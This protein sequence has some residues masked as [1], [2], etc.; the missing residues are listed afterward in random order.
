MKPLPAF[1][2]AAMLGAGS[3][4]SLEAQSA[5]GS[6]DGLVV[7]QSRA[8]VPGV[9]ITVLRPAT[10]ATRTLVT[11]A[12]GRFRAPL[13]PVGQYELTATLSGFQTI[14][15]DVTLTVGQSLSVHLELSA[16]GPAETVVVSA[17]AE[18]LERTR[19]SASSTVDETAIQNLP[20]NGRSFVDFALLTPGVTRDRTGDLSFAGQRSTLNGLVVDGADNNNTFFG[21]ALGAGR[22]PYQFSQD[23][24]QEFQVNSNAFSA[25]YGRAGAGLINVVTKSGTNVLRGSLFEYYRDVA[26]NAISAIN[27]LNH[28]P[29]S[30]YHYHQFGGTLGGSLRANRDFFFFGYDGQ[31]NRATQQVFLNLPPDTPGDAATQS[32]IEKLRPFVENWSRS[33]NQD[34]FLIKTDHAFGAGRRLTLRY[35]HQNFTGEGYENFGPQQA[36]EHSGDSLVRTRTLNA[37]WAGVIGSRFF[38]EMRLQFARDHEPGTA[39]GDNPEA[40]IQ[41]GGTRVFLIGRNNFSPRATTIDRVQAADTLTWTSGRHALKAGFDLQF[42]RIRTYF[43]GFFSGSY[44][45]RSLASFDRGRPDGPGEGY[46]QS[47]PGPGTSGAETRPDLREYSLFVQDDWQLRSDLSVSVGLRYDLMATNG[48]GVRNPDPDLIAAGI[49]TGRFPTDTDNLGPRLGAAWSPAGRPYVVRGGW[50]LFYGRTPMVMATSAAANNG[51]NTISLT[52]NGQAVPTYPQKFT[53]IPAGGAAGVPS[54]VYIDESFANARL[55]QANLGFEWEVARGTSLAVTYLR[56]NGGDLPRSVDRN[57]GTLGARVVT[58]A[59]AGQAVSTPFFGADRPFRNFQR[60]IAFESSAES[61]YNGLTLELNR[62]FS[63]ATQF[64]VAYTAARAVDTVPDATAVLP[65]NPTDDMKHASNPVDFDVDRTVG[66]NDQRH[67]LVTSAVYSSSGLA[68]GLEGAVRA[69]AAGWWVS[70]IFTAQSGQPHSAR[71]NGDLNGDGNPRNDFTPGSPRNYGVLPAMVTLDLRIA[72]D[73]PIRGRARA[74]IIWEAFNLFNRDNINGINLFQ[75]GLQ[76]ATLTP[77]ADFG[78]PVSSAG[79]RIMQLAFK[80]LF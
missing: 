27:E 21:R 5:T 58:I 30:P 70:A 41:Q 10:G 31:R 78:Q 17:P 20:V 55:M 8:V 39:N 22:A 11:D 60:V 73:V 37:S 50:G 38:N 26:L 64:R 28:L 34:V 61:S 29:K 47:F 49:D 69:L 42:D 6:I 1:L 7:D 25:E 80:V 77:I 44:T 16:A 46:R 3:A 24:V 76:G 51:L 65:G 54:I 72:R 45:F 18:A 33:L 40:D 12:N 48:S 56:V 53:D 62:R 9:K 4:L 19:H 59:P 68:S 57:V 35:N 23:T 13:L 2:A 71:I 66:I 67:R 14:E 63:G 75:Y 32:A 74:Q 36:H 79:E 52:F 15:R 43:P